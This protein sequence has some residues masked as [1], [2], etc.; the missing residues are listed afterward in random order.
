MKCNISST[1]VLVWKQKF[2]FTYK[3]KKPIKAKVATTT[4]NTKICLKPMSKSTSKL[5][6][7]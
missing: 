5:A 6:T 3:I 1:A 7:R 4:R 2:T